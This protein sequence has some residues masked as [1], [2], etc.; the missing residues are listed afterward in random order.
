VCDTTYARTV[1]RFGEKGVIDI[2]GIV[3]YYT[4][5]AMVMNVARTAIPDGKPLPLA[6]MP[7]ELAP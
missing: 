4:M 5:L 7:L 1:K 2:L 3:G 6:P